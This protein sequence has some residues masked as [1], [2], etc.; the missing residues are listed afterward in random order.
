MRIVAC[1]ALLQSVA[2]A[3][4]FGCFVDTHC[5]EGLDSETHQGVL[6]DA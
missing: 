1:I 4:D 5:V 3:A 2:C 6:I